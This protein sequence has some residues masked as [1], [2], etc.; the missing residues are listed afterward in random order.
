M[1]GS[2]TWS[3]AMSAC[4]VVASL[5][6]TPLGPEGPLH[7]QAGTGTVRGKVTNTAGAPVPN[8]QVF[9]AGT[10]NGGQSGADGSFTITRVTAGTATVRVRMIGY[11]PTEKAATVTANGTATVDF[12]LKTSA[13][14]LDQVVVTGTAGSARKREVGNSIGQVS[15][16]N[17]PEVPTNVSN[18]L[19]GRVAGVQISGGTGNAGSGSAIRLRG[20]T[21]I[22][23]SNQPLIYVDGVRTRSDE[24]P[25]NGIFQGATQRG[26]NSYGSP[27]NDI[28]PDDIER[29]EVVKGAAATTLFGTDAAAGVIQIFTKRGSQGAAKWNTQINSGFQRLQRFGTDSVPLLN[30]DPFVRDGGRLGMQAQVAGGTNNNVRYLFSF[31]ADNSDGVLELDNERKYQLRANVDF[32]PM[33]NM[34]FSW[35]TAYNNS[36]IT[37]TPA[38]NNAQGVTLNA[39]RQNRNYFGNANA[40]TIKLVY[41]QQLTSNIDRLLLGAT[42]TWTPFERFSSR[43]V[44]GFDRSAIE[45]RNV[46]P[47][48]FPG[49]VLGIIQNQ[50]WSNKII[51]LDWANNYEMSKGDFKATLSAGSQ[52]VNSVVGDVVAYSE[53]YPAPINPTV[54]SGSLRNADENRLKNITGGAFSQALF[55]F[56]DKYFVTVGARVDG[57]SAFGEDFG[58]QTYPKASASWVVSDE[59]FWGDAL[60]TMKLRA[61]YGQA[62]RAPTAFAAVQTWNSVPWGGAPAVR[63]L[64]LGDPNLGPE[65]TTETEIGFDNTLFDGRFSVDFTWFKAVT[66]D[67]L[68]FVRNVPS[69]G[70][71]A[72]SL[73]N[74]GKIQKSG[75]EAAINATLLEKQNLGVKVGLNVS[76][77]Q[78]K[79]LD[80][81]G[82]PDFSI[83]NFGWV[84]KGQPAPVLR[85]RLIKNEDEIGAAIDTTVNHT[86]GPA[87]PT[88][89]LSP[90][91]NI[92]TWKG[93]SISARGEYQGGAFINED[94]SFQALS[95]SVLWPTCTRAYAAI[96]A[97]QP[98]TPR[99]TLTCIPRNAR[100]D[101]F[102]FPA[103]FFKIRDITVTVPLGKL[104]PNTA[105]SSLVLSAQNVFRKNIGMPLFDPE[106]SGNDGFNVGVR[107]ISEH[108]PAPALFLTSLRIT[109]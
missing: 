87:Q 89:I 35:N 26:A 78:S 27:L 95:R 11:E 64:N 90:M 14:S 39:F 98:L 86:F 23:L 76:T 104:I 49:A 48:G 94:A 47:Y 51:S 32:S 99:E 17:L 50:V 41:G 9:I 74:A 109:F 20:A 101:M 38:G 16:A 10:Q 36:L 7:A 88:L 69:R 103:D 24:Y 21:S 55:G 53:N 84:I 83:G 70:F 5:L 105:S 80:L 92:T 68:F 106:M 62:G 25:R 81:G 65:R 91:L 1:I 93:I 28:N 56:R 97:S 4:A 107:Y 15:T 43:L 96:A 13:V 82:A 8:A 72:S 3:R 22:A 40:D 66:D 45:N 60:G 54:Q 63:P 33:K 85:G 34:Q 37:Q 30:M 46:R 42:T 52:Y 67:A 79:V 73:G 2:Q 57:N 102:I 19:A 31:G 6:V 77:N 71:L 75:V 18:L 58:F 59:G 61:A 108:I 12:V 44:V 29:I 100:Q